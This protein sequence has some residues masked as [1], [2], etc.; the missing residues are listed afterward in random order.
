MPSEYII[1]IFKVLKNGHIIIRK[2]IRFF[3]NFFYYFITVI[4][5]FSHLG[6]ARQLNFF[7]KIK[8]INTGLK[9]NL[10]KKDINF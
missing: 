3:Y 2:L 8:E 4:N 6:T 7:H 10:I 9:M 1:C 5:F